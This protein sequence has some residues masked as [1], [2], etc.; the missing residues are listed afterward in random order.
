[1][2]EIRCPHCKQ[3]FQVDD[4]GYASLVQQV[5]DAEFDKAL[6][7]ALSM[8]TELIEKDAQKSLLEKDGRIELLLKDIEQMKKDAQASVSALQERYE[9]KITLLET[10]LKDEREKAEADRDA[11][12]AKSQSDLKDELHEKERTIASL[13]ERLSQ[14]EQR[15][16]QDVELAVSKVKQEQSEQHHALV[17]EL[18]AAKRTLEQEKV[19]HEVETE[20]LRAHH[21]EEMEI[22]LR[23][24]DEMIKERERTIEDLRDMKQR[25]TV[26]MLGESLEQHCENAFNKM[27]SSAFRNAEFKKD[28]DVID[29]TKGD[30]IYREK[31]AEGAELISIMFEMKTESDTSTHRKKNE[32]H[33]KKLDADRRKKGCEYAVLVSTLEAES[34]YYN[35]GIVDVSHLY[36]KMYVIRP[37]FFIPMI[38]LLRNAAESA[39][40]YKNELELVRRQNIDVTHFEEALED[41][42]GKFGKNYRLASERFQKAIEEIDKTIE[43]LNKVKEGLLGSERNLRL[44]NDKAEALT[45]KKLTRGNPTMKAAFDELEKD[46]E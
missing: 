37:Q 45:V 20:R 16:E 13:T 6:A 24:K 19:Q 5:R 8:R 46:D 30:Y 40:S 33:L 25:L 42:K 44:A 28:S 3:V 22:R 36:E 7:D 29:G 17:R 9:S 31:T 1:M 26:K 38:T 41:F 11:A 35:E 34:E 18:D 15:L 2:A 10:S 39:A 23:S 4:A 21:K 27:R 12:I 32:D 43:H 14:T